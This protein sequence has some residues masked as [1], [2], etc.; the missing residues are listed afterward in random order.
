[1]KSKQTASEEQKQSAPAYIVT[2]S[3]MVT[4]LLTFF[5]LLL[6]LAETQN[7]ELLKKGQSSFKQAIAD[8]GISGLFFSKHSEP[9]FDHPKVKYHID[10]GKDKPEDR[11]ID[12]QTEML[13]RTIM[14]LEDMMKITPSQITASLSSFIITDIHFET[15]SHLLNDVAKQSLHDH[16]RQIQES[17][18]IEK[19]ALYVVGLAGDEPTEMQQWTLS[20]RRA[21]AVVDF[22][23]GTLSR[24]KNWPVYSWGAGPGGDWTG[25]TGLITKQTEIMIAVLTES[26]Q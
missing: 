22:L 7:E 1:M 14:R 5:V 18:N 3:D 8:F 19:A 10:Q 26:T 16:C 21:Q 25:T 24:N 15:G 6:S 11:S 13:R 17:F 23:K 2:F 12:A 4:L 20:A 9:Q